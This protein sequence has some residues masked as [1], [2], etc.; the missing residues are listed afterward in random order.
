[1]AVD[2]DVAADVAI[3]ERVAGLLMVTEEAGAAV[4][5]ARTVGDGTRH[6]DMWGRLG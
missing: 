2:V 3:E 5:E 1:M 4:T 6:A